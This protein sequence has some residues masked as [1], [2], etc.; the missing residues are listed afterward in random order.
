[1]TSTNNY[2]I[3][4]THK[5]RPATKLFE[6]DFDCHQTRLHRRNPAIFTPDETTLSTYGDSVDNGPYQQADRPE[7][8]DPLESDS[9]D[10]DSVEPPK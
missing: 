8:I 10:E 9:D 1:M 7:I 6:A 5:G 4:Q 2:Q 3:G